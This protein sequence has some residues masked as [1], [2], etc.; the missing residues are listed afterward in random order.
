MKLKSTK[1]FKVNLIFNSIYQIFMLI[2]PFI[3]APYVS[4]VLLESQV[5]AYSYSTSIVYY[6]TSFAAFG[7]LDYGTLVISKNRDDK[8]KYSKLFYELLICKFI[9]TFLSLLVYAVIVGFN[10]LYSTSYPENTQIIYVILGLNILSTAFDV[11]FLFQGLER[12]VSLCLRN[13]FIKLINIILIF[14]LVR[15]SADFQ[16]YV[17]IMVSCTLLSTLITFANIPFLCK[18]PSFKDIHILQHF[19]GS[20]AFF[21]PLFCLA[22]MSYFPKTILGIF[23]KDSVQSGYFEQADRLIG[24]INSAISSLNSILLSRMAYLYATKNEEEIKRK[25]VQ[26]LNL[27]LLLAIPAILGLISIN[28]YFTT[29]FFGD[30]YENC[31]PLVYIMAPRILF[32]PF[33]AIIGAIYFIPRGEILK[34]NIFY[35]SGTAFNIL[36]CSLLS[37]FFQTY[38]AAA[39]YMIAEGFMAILFYHFSRKNFDYKAL[40]TP[41]SKIFDAALIMFVVLYFVSSPIA[42][43]FS[44]LVTSFI[45]IAIGGIV[46][47]LCLILFKEKM[48]YSIFM[49]YLKKAQSILKRSH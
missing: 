41:F 49:K 29:G 9:L 48:S 7:F 35:I 47:G 32:T 39:G 40:L 10:G 16:N 11:T 44:G 46:Y 23:G 24:I 31:I 8:A 14:T 1:N 25:S 6:F 27:Y 36:V 22:V 21:I 26:T 13:A 45:M 3:T 28:R 18:K 17:I 37:Y 15:T 4:R 42:N 5:G 38:G 19:K 12:F 33:Y 20:L 34:R 2:V 43:H 30:K